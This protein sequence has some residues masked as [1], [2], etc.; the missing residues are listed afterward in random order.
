MHSH[1]RTLAQ[2]LMADPD[3]H[4][5]LHDLA[6]QYLVQPAPAAAL[7]KKTWVKYGEAYSVERKREFT[8][9]C[10]EG[11]YKR[12][13]GFIDVAI[14]IFKSRWTMAEVKAG[15]T[16][17]GDCIRQINFYKAYGPVLSRW[18]LVTLYPLNKFDAADLEAVGIEHVVLGEEFYR[19]VKENDLD[20]LPDPPNVDLNS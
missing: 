4:S 12:V 14:K 1:D 13:V 9:T 5:P 6:C 17:V 3:K 19:W 2:A 16:P 20:P 8:V 10:G 7:V 18:V 11:V 15:R